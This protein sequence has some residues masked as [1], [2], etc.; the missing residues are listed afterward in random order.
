M[1]KMWDPL[2]NDFP[3]TV[4][5]FRCMLAT[6]YLLEIE[7][8][9]E[10][11]CVG[12]LFIRDLISVVR[13]PNYVEATRRYNHFHTRFKGTTSSQLR[14]PACSCILCPHHQKAGMGEQADV[15]QAQNVPHVAELRC[16]QGL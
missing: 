16:S 15:S 5:G 8:T 12:Q 7:K 13:A 3:S 6:K 2:C 1:V 11:N 10:P 4:H 9:Y 14:Q